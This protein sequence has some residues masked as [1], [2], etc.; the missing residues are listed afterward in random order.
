MLE[1][2]TNNAEATTNRTTAV[3]GFVGMARALGARFMRRRFEPT[4]AIPAAMRLLPN[5][6]LPSAER[7][8]EAAFARFEEALTAA[9]ELGEDA[10]DFADEIM[11][12]AET[13]LLAELRG[14]FRVA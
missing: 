13:Q 7:R 14:E 4:D 12:D 9:V 2:N 1:F 10:L 6:G 5:D 11:A 8:A 3:G